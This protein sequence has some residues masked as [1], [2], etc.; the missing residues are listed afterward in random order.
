MPATVLVSSF[1]TD[2]I[3]V[4]YPAFSRPPRR[5]YREIYPG[6]EFRT[7]PVSVKPPAGGL[8]CPALV[9]CNPPTFPGNSLYPR[10]FFSHY[11]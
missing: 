9:I 2:R 11:E 3:G 8:Y 7:A 1:F 6:R 10:T 5:Q 4:I